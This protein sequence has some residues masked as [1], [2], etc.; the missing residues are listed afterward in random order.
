MFCNVYRH[1]AKFFK[2]CVKILVIL[3]RY[4]GNFECLN[5]ESLSEANVLYY[6]GNDV[7]R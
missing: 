3:I 7:P 1:I 6:N 4:Q 5:F 2:K